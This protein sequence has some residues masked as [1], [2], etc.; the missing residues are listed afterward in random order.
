MSTS[1]QHDDMMDVGFSHGEET[2]TKKKFKKINILVFFACIV[3]AFAFW[4]YAL[5]VNDP[6]IKKTVPVEL[7]LVGGAEGETLSASPQTIE[8]WGV[9]STL[10]K[11]D[12]ITVKVNRSSVSAPDKD[13][14]LPITLPQ[15]V[16]SKTERIT[17]RLTVAE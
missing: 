7:Q 15:N 17:V 12:R 4:C 8:I 5:Q 6:I 9:R 14:E 16:E 13:I 10:D 1:H 2:A 3:L 11:V